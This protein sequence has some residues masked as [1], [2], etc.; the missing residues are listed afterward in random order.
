MTKPSFDD[1][2]YNKPLDP[3]VAKVEQRV[4]RLFLIAT[5]TLGLG[6]FAVFAAI[7]YRITADDAPPDAVVTADNAGDHARDEDAIRSALAE[8]NAAF[9]AGKTETICDLFAPDLR[10]FASGIEA[11]QGYD[12]VC[13]RLTAALADR[14]RTMSYA[15]DIREVIVTG[16]TAIARLTWTLT[17]RPASGGEAV[18]MTREQGMDYF[19]RQ[20]DGSWKIARFIS[21]E[22]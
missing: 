17:I 10:S 20:P 15:L 8:W 13:S 12:A 21:Y 5:L 11:E 9:N 14:T 22:E 4:R 3:A 1:D 19:R 2:E 18:V 16:N 7:I 6:I